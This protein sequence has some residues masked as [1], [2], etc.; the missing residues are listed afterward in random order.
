MILTKNELEVMS[1]L[2]SAN[3]DLTHTEIIELSINP[4]WK[5]STIHTL[6]NGLL[7][8]NLIQV[9]NLK[10]SGKIFGRTFIPIITKEEYLAY[11]V[12]NSLPQ[13]DSV[14]LASVVSALYKGKK[15]THETFDE[16]KKVLE[17]LEKEIVE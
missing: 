6:I 8:K 12:E 1:V 5:T 11:Q 7:K 10:L 3:K 17:A 14:Q 15:M 2:W 13:S 4:S 9:S 16:L